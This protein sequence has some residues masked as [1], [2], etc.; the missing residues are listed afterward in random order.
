MCKMATIQKIQK[1]KILFL[2]STK[3]LF[4]LKLQKFLVFA[5]LFLFSCSSNLIKAQNI[6]PE[7]LKC[8]SNSSVDFFKKNGLFT[9]HDKD[10]NYKLG[11]ID[12][13]ISNE[14]FNIIIISKPNSTGGYTL[15]IQKIIKNGKNFKIYLKEN[16][17]LI[18]SSNIMALTATY[19][20][21]KIEN[22]NKVKA[23]NS[24]T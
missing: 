14:D 23:F 19:C 24:K 2:F 8:G 7:D 15:K 6:K 11:L 10:F 3:K 21:L 13:N 18:G 1:I 17:P 20:M 12:K 5:A 16:K 22:F 9:K 4:N